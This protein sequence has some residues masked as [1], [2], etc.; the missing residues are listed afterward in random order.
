MLSGFLPQRDTRQDAG[1]RSK[2][3]YVK[4]LS[5]LLFMLLVICVPAACVVNPC[6][7]AS[8]EDVAD[9]PDSCFAIGVRDW[10]DEDLIIEAR[11]NGQNLS[12]GHSIFFDSTDL[13]IK[14]LPDE[15]HLRSVEAR[16]FR[17]I[18][19]RVVASEV[20][21]LEDFER[22]ALDVRDAT[23]VF[24]RPRIIEA[25][26]CDVE[27]G[28]SPWR[29]IDITVR[30]SLHMR[31]ESETEHPCLSVFYEGPLYRGQSD[32]NSFALDIDEGVQPNRELHIAVSE[33]TTLDH[34]RPL[35]GRAS[36]LVISAIGTA[37]QGPAGSALL[38]EYAAWLESVGFGGAVSH[39]FTDAT[40]GQQTC[41]D[42]W[43]V[44]D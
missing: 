1:K 36:E 17:E 12:L 26:E 32:W 16:G 14:W 21:T 19:G 20:V 24:L 13:S 25:T 18:A 43:P 5:T 2:V 34:L 22:N 27:E 23:D 33:W 7:V 3:H 15:L 4:S 42:G 30:E 9:A 10:P 11:H 41:F 38:D 8:P 28:L 37:M 29:R 35:G 44:F 39:C 31:V 40:T 6:V